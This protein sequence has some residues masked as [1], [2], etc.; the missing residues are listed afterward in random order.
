MDGS[1]LVELQKRTDAVRERERSATVAARVP[2]FTFSEPNTPIVTLPPSTMTAQQEMDSWQAQFRKLNAAG[3][4][5]IRQP[6][7]QLAQYHLLQ[8]MK[9][10]GIL[11]VRVNAL[12]SAPPNADA[13]GVR[14]FVESSGV[15]PNEGDEWVR[16]QGMKLVAD[17]GF[18]GGWLREPY[19][20]PYGKDGHYKL[21]L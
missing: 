9:R 17:G 7:I 16:I 10:R 5:S 6:G 21:K 20:E 3:L 4:T 15:K 12:L 1:D 8:D 11:T 14:A 13:A 18:E 19:Q 2:S